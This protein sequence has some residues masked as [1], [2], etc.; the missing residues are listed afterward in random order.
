[1]KLTKLTPNLVVADVSRSVAFYRDLL[2][3][4][5]AMSV[6][7][8]PPYVFAGV[9]RDGIEIFFNAPE[10]V[11]EEMP[12]LAG[13]PIG[14]TLTL[15]IEVDDVKGLYE[16]VKGRARLVMDL[17]DQFYGMREFVIADPDGYL[18]TFS[19]RIQS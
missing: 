5:M 12:E 19:Q 4:E 8:Q 1:M 15:Y 18:L 2:G 16:T 7:E 17:K 6:P 14:G 13:R 9:Q 3:F 11:A 10:P